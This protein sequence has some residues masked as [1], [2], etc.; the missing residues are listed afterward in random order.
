MMFGDDVWRWA[1][2]AMIVLL[3]LALAGCGAMIWVMLW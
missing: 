3:V 2:R 1:N